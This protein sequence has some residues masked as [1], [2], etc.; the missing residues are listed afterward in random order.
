MCVREAAIDEPLDSQGLDSVF[1]HVPRR[2]PTA[3]ITQILEPHI[4]QEL[5]GGLKVRDHTEMLFFCFSFEINNRKL[6]NKN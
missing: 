5:K 1:K 3:K 6:Y 2:L 4:S